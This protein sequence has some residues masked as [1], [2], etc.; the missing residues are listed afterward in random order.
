MYMYVCACAYESVEEGEKKY[1]YQ[2]LA[3]HVHGNYMY[4]LSLAMSSP[5]ASQ[6][7]QPGVHRAHET[8]KGEFSNISE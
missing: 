3:Q 8:D 2:H 5:Q 7:V 4:V 1:H 6:L